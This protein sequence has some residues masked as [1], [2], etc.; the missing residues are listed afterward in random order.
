MQCEI[1]KLNARTGIKK[2]IH[3]RCEENAEFL[4]RIHGKKYYVCKRHKNKGIFI[5]KLGT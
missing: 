5:K 4:V 2:D 1:I 3:K